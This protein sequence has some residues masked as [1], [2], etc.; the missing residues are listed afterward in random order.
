MVG[1]LISLFAPFAHL[2]SLHL[3]RTLLGF[4]VYGPG[5]RPNLNYSTIC[6][7]WESWRSFRARKAYLH[8]PHL[9]QASEAQP[10]DHQ[11][12]LY[13]RADLRTHVL[14]F[15][16]LLCCRHWRLQLLHGFATHGRDFLLVA[17]S[18]QGINVALIT[19]CGL[20]VPIDLVS[21]FCTPAEVMTARTAPPAITPV[22]SGAGF[23]STCRNRT[24][25]HLRAE[26][27]SV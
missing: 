9:V 18:A 6:T 8:A 15:D 1:T 7:R 5:N 27:W 12:M 16:C 21:T 13:R 14:N 20:A 2:S 11:L 26:S 3:A 19:L 4:H 24:S 22:P 25:Q 17:Q 23:S 10:F